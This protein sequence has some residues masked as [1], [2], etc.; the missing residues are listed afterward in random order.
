MDL[1]LTGK[2][3]LVT[4]ATRGIRRAIAGR[5]APGGRARAVRA[6]YAEAVATAAEEMR[7]GGVTVHA[8]AVDVTDGPALERFVAGA[9]EALGGL[10]PLG[11]NAGRSRRR[12]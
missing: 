4:G 9:G 11:A 6:R 7:A 2:R 10:D 1:E 12:A 3:A 8:Q 5:L